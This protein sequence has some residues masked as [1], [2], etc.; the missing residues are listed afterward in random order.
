MKIEVQRKENYHFMLEL[1][2][3]FSKLMFL[4]IGMKQLK[5]TLNG[6]KIQMKFEY[7]I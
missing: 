7:N 6:H 1:S 5:F 2:M 3:Q 4:G